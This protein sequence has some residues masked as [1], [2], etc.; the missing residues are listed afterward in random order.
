MVPCITAV[1]YFHFSDPPATSATE[2]P[3]APAGLLGVVLVPRRPLQ[4]RC[5]LPAAAAPQQH[6]RH[7]EP[8]RRQRRER[9]ERAQ[10]VDAAAGEQAAAGERPLRLP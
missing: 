8:E 9:R 3:R 1:Q 6:Q 4:P 2:E 10:V 7:R 5:Q